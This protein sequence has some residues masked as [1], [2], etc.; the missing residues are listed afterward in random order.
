MT[1]TGWRTVRNS[2]A[3]GRFVA[4]GRMARPENQ[5]ETPCTPT[6]P[7]STRTPRTA[8]RTN[9]PQGQY[10]GPDS[11]RDHGRAALYTS[12]GA[13]ALAIVGIVTAL[14]VGLGGGSAQADNAAAPAPH[15]ASQV[16]ANVPA[17]NPAPDTDTCPRARPCPGAAQHATVV[18]RSSR[19]QQQLAQ[20]NYYDGPITGYS[21]AQYIQAIQYLQRDAHLPQTRSAHPATQQAL[22]YML[23]HGNN[24]MAG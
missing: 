10:P 5:G 11:R 2:P 1:S 12:I 16:P 21:N 14:V 15:H 17:N 19:L 18:R 22:Q 3:G 9:S 23:V 8:W 24:Q 6:R 4:P 7:R 20:L 13:A